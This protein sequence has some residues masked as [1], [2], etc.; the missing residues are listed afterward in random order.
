VR[1]ASS[2]TE[3]VF[4]G[5][6]CRRGVDGAHKLRTIHLEGVLQQFSLAA[7]ERAAGIECSGHFEFHSVGGVF[8]VRFLCLEV[9]C[10]SPSLQRPCRS[11]ETG[12]AVRRFT[13]RLAASVHHRWGRERISE[14]RAEEMKGGIGLGH[15]AV[16]THANRCVLPS[17][18]SMHDHPQHLALQSVSI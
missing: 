16:C 11:H 10:L 18:P 7:G 14:G 8:G 12:T 17:E 15:P 5:L 9:P 6:G 3:P 1:S 2:A 4:H 13:G